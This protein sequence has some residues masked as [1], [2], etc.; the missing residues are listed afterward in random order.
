MLINNEMDDFSSKPGTPNGYGLLG[1]EANAIEGNK[2]PLSSMTPTII[3]KNN[4]PYVILGS[5][6]GSRI[7]TTVLQVAI[8]VM[9]HDMNI[10]QAVHSPRIHHQWY[11][12]RLLF[13]PMSLSADTQALLRAKGHELGQT[14]LARVHSIVVDLQG[15]LT[16]GVDP[17]GDGY[18]A[19]Y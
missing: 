19:G 8:N 12:D 15:R 4:E 7:I 9:D 11:P 16:G 6:G 3:F 2:R 17:R 1:S 14:T 10:A 5:P 13:D 18:A